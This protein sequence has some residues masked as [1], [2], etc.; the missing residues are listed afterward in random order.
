MVL[1]GQ[2]VSHINLFIILGLGWSE[3]PRSDIFGIVGLTRYSL[4]TSSQCI[5]VVG[6]AATLFWIK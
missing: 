3:Y 4:L 2:Q 6:V 5:G 1:T